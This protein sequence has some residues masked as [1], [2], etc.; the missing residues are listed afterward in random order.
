VL[1]PEE[2][3]DGHGVEEFVHRVELGDFVDVAEVDYCEV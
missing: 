1:V 3:H 2:E